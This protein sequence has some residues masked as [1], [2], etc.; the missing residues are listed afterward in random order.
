MRRIIVVVFV[1]FLVV[2]GVVS[3]PAEAEG[4]SIASPKVMTLNL[5]VGADLSSF[6]P[7]LILQTIQQT[8]FPERSKTIADEIDDRNP[9]L[10]GLQEVSNISLTFGPFGDPVLD[11]ETGEPVLVLDYLEIL[12]ADLEA[13]GETYVK[14]SEIVNAKVSL[15][16]DLKNNIWG[17]LI[18]R[19]VILAR[20]A[21]T[22]TS[23]PRS[24]NY[25]VNF[26]VEVPLPPPLPP[27]TVEFTRG[28]TT[29]DAVV[30]GAAF[31]FANTHLEVEPDP[32][33]GAGFCIVEKNPIPCQIPQAKQLVNEVL[34]DASHP[35]ILL[36]DFNAEPGTAAYHTVANAG[37]VDAWDEQIFDF[38]L[39]EDTCCQKEDLSNTFSK[40]DQRIDIIFVRTEG[41][42][43][44]IATVVFDRF[45]EK[46]PSGLW[47]TDHGSVVARLFYPNP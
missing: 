7:P 1:G 3:T 43:S 18:D 28:W 42:V 16:I 46:T 19:D 32:E 30:N 44:S 26:Q 13:E 2:L 40:L 23:H 10:I 35:T 20:K 24:G 12:L 37:F 4:P 11:P 21:T 38:N 14:A 17:N 33:T 6:D 15:P 34:K 25:A 39:N 9:D 31:T 27:A 41:D 29:V 8:N 45:W 47:P 36:G 5:Y 22:S